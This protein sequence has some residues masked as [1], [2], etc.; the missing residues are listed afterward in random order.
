MKE[1]HDI[2]AIVDLTSLARHEAGHLLMLWLLACYAASGS[3]DG[4]GIT[5][6]FDAPGEKETPSEFAI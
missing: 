6:A 1:R 5:K 4:C 2:P 3:A